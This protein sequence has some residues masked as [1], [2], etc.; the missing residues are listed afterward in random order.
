MSYGERYGMESLEIDS[1]VGL[2]IT[3][4]LI[5]TEKDLV[6]L[7]T[8]QGKRYLSWVGD[9]CAHC[10][11]EHVSG[12]EFLIGSKISKAVNAEWVDISK[13]EDYGVLQSMGSTI[14]TDKGILTIET[15]LS[16]NGYYGGRIQISKEGPIDQY[17]SPRFDDFEFEKDLVNLRDF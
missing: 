7:G 8:D 1:L 17:S 10:F 11:I 5:N 14:Q 4:A 2:T 13:T 6:V 3:N 12:V 15:R 16:H 9:C